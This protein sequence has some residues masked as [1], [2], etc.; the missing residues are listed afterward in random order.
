V[1]EESHEKEI[2]KL[3]MSSEVY[4]CI[5]IGA[6]IHGVLH[7]L[8]AGQKPAENFTAGAGRLQHD[9]Q[10]FYDSFKCIHKC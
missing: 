4:D 5:V 7:C 6:G 8:S 2:T 10:T 1:S 9:L 3:E